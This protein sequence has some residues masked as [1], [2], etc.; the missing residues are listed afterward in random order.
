MEDQKPCGHKSF[1]G[2]LELLSYSPVAADGGTIISYPDD[3]AGS[4][5]AHNL[6]I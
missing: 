1:M 2:L 5:L 4:R 3:G 6:R